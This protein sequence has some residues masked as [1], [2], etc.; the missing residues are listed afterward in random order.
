[1][2]RH[3][4]IFLDSVHRHIKRWHRAFDWSVSFCE[5][6]SHPS[7]ISE[8]FNFSKLFYQ[9]SIFGLWHGS[10]KSLENVSKCLPNVY[11]IFNYPFPIFVKT[12]LILWT[13]FAVST[14]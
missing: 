12:Q 11:P 14:S 6:M 10:L 4:I 3:P 2:K 8:I 5:K 9:I 1:M 13:F 7:I